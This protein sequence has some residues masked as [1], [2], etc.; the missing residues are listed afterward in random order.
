MRV[1][2]LQPNIIEASVIGG[3]AKGE[4]VF[5]PRI[6]LISSDYPFNF[7]RLQ[8][9]IKVCFAITINKAQGQSLCVAGIDLRSSCFSHGQFYVACSRISEKKTFIHFSTQ[10]SN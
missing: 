10:Q 9:P 3:C 7:K 2:A 5:I 1:T 6:P 4:K 8:F